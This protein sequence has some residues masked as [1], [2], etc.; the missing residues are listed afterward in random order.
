MLSDIRIAIE[1]SRAALWRDLLGMAA[2]GIAFY[3]GLHLPMLASA[4]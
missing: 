2:L 3:A 4:A 1:G